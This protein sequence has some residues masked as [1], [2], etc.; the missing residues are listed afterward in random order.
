MRCP[1][2]RY[3]E[4]AGRDEAFDVV[5]IGGGIT[6]ACVAYESASRGLKTA[7]FEKGDFGAATSAA[8]SKLI[9]GGLRYLNYF[10]FRLVRQSLRERRILEDIAPNFVYPLPFLIPNYDSLKSNKW[11]IK[12]GMILYDILSFDKGWTEHRS[13]RIPYHHS[14][15]AEEVLKIAP[16]LRSGKLTGGSVYY[17]CQS[18]FPERLTLAFIKSAVASGA[19]VSN[20]AE[21]NGFEKDGTRLSAVRVKDRETGNEKT[22]RGS[23]F[24]NSGGPWAGRLLEEMYGRPTAHAV[25]MSEGIHIITPDLGADHALVLLTPQGRHFFVIPWRGHSLIGTTDK[26]YKGSPD[27]YRVS[28]E[29]IGEFIKEING[30]FGREVVRYEDVIYAYGGLRPL[31]DTHT[32]GTYSSSR[33]HEIIDGAREGMEGL[34]TVEGGKYTTSRDLGESVMKIV[35]QRLGK[36]LPKTM[37]DKTPLKGCDIES[38]SEFTQNEIKLHPDFDRGTIV[39]LASSYG[40]EIED[41]IGIA[42]KDPQMRAVLNDSGEILAQAVHA[43]RFEMARHLSDVMLRRTGLGTLGCPPDDILL[44]VGRAVGKELG[45]TEDTIRRECGEVKDLLSVPPGK[46]S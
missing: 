8:T 11:L 31:T 13:K 41:V 14:V 42:E 18:V 37:T 26:E 2:E 27:E 10:E 40:T 24:V 46:Q 15:T 30:A 21:V 6:G 7:L 25:K 9:H 32:K 45:W 36:A 16:A 5:V 43:V 3:I 1:M 39:S 19:R 33:R 17:D 23:L 22:I 28:A 4:K 34:I 29:S 12:A 35:S 44:R 20:Y 38:L